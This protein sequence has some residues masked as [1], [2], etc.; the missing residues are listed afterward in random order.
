MSISKDRIQE[1]ITEYGGSEENTGST[2]AQIALF[3][4]RINH[5]TEHL[6]ENKLDHASRR[7]LLMLVGKRKR[8]LTYLKNT[9]I[10]GY[11]ELIQ[12]LGIRK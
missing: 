6:K 9:D 4:A 2:E 5:L 12:K 10:E 8:Q 3:T 7:G 11:R 1:V